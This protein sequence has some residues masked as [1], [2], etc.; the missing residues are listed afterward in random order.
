MKRHDRRGGWQGDRKSSCNGGGGDGF[1]F[2]GWCGGGIYRACIGS[3]FRKIDPVAAHLVA[4]AGC[5]GHAGEAWAGIRSCQG[6]ERGTV[7]GGIAAGRVPGR[8]SG[9]IARIKG[10][11]RVVGV[12]RV[13]EEKMWLRTLWFPTPVPRYQKDGGGEA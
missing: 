11:E 9:Q 6:L 4:I 10:A 3:P 8:G 1:R 12:S 7:L 5:P 13:A 2:N